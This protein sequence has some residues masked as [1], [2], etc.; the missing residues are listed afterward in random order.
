MNDEANGIAQGDELQQPPPLRELSIITVVPGQR[1]V[2]KVPEH[3]STE[4]RDRLSAH[5]GAWWGGDAPPPPILVLDGGMDLLATSG[6]RPGRV[7][8]LLEANNRMHERVTVMA[9]ELE[10]ARAAQVNAETGKAWAMLSISNMANGLAL[11]RDQFLQYEELHRAKGTE[12]AD[13]KAKVNADFAQALQAVMDKNMTLP[14]TDEVPRPVVT[15]VGQEDAQAALDDV[16][17]PSY[18]AGYQDGF[19]DGHACGEGAGPH[20]DAPHIVGLIDHHCVQDGWTN[21]TSGRDRPTAQSVLG[22]LAAGGVGVVTAFMQ[23]GGAYATPRGLLMAFASFAV[24]QLRQRGRQQPES[25]LSR[26]PLRLVPPA[27]GDD[28]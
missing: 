2:L 3:I 8:E 14:G 21:F 11:A 9:N 19:V 17:L 12:D 15:V 22:A 18:R 20:G 1:L 23:S 5:V 25:A 13:R 16:Q 26:A 10:A 6:E 28:A 27:G 4:T 24:D 7:D